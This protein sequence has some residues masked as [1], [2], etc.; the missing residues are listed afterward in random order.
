MARTTRRELR[1]HRAGR[2]RTKRR[3]VAATTAALML[4]GSAALATIS[5]ITPTGLQTVTSF[6]HT[7]NVSA[8][9]SNN[10]PDLC[11]GQG[12]D[13][14]LWVLGTDGTTILAGADASGS[15]INVGSPGV[16]AAGASKVETLSNVSFP[17]PGTY[18]IRATLKSRTGS[19]INDAGTETVNWQQETTI[20]VDYPAAPAV[21]AKLLN[22][23]GVKAKHPGGNYISEVAHE[24]D[25][26]TDFRTVSKSS[27]TA[28]EAAVRAFLVEQGALAPLAP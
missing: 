10:T 2:A 16:C 5:N 6:P 27:V 1:L 22:A 19:S 23:A 8:T 11:Q 15:Y 14:R 18:T 20:V 21:A 13:W 12:T 3:L 28:Y 25:P 7:A 9:F 17:A 4:L 26:G 24:M